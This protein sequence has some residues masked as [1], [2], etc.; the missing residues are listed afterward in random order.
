MFA[1][2]YGCVALPSLAIMYRRRVGEA[3]GHLQLGVEVVVVERKLSGPKKP[4][5]NTKVGQRSTPR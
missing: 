1:V 5:N 4:L 3:I 2:L